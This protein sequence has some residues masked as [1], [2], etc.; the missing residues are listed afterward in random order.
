[1]HMELPEYNTLDKLKSLTLKYVKVLE[2]LKKTSANFRGVHM[3]GDPNAT[4]PAHYPAPPEYAAPPPP[5]AFDEEA[6]VEKEALEILACT[7]ASEV[8]ADVWLL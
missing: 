7:S 5:P 1:M 6:E 8:P 3:L 4:V 2:N